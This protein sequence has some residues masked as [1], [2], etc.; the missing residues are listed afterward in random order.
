MSGAA[1]R[2]IVR[3]FRHCDGTVTA[4]IVRLQ[5]CFYVSLRNCNSTVYKSVSDFRL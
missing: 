4:L 3:K 1:W 2:N 5:N